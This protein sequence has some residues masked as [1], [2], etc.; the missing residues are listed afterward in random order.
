MGEI[1][2]SHGKFA[3]AFF[4]SVQ[5][6]STIGYGSLAPAPTSVFAN[7]IADLEAAFGSCHVVHRDE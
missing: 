1:D 4:W 6:M 2:H 5:T 7:V 3:D